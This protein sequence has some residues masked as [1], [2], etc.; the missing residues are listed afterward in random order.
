LRLGVIRDIH[1]SEKLFYRKVLDIYATSVEYDPGVA[2]SQM[3]FQTVRRY[4]T[5]CIGRRTATLPPRS[6]CP[7]P[8]RP[9]ITWGWHRPH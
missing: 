7:A 1:P 4:R 5:K 8:M 3:F 2:A 9:R 6:W